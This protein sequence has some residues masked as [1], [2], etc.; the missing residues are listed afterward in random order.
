MIFFLSIVITKVIKNNHDLI[1]KGESMEKITEEEVRKVIENDKEK[2]QKIIDEGGKI[3]KT[4]IEDKNKITTI[5]KIEPVNCEATS[6]TIIQN[7]DNITV[8]CL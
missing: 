6:S 2:M 8:S 7:K 3:T 1:Q 5:I 4:I